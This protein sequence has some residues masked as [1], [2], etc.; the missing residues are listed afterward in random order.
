MKHNL[1]YVISL[2]FMLLLTQSTWADPTVTIIKQLNGAVVTETSPGVV[3][4]EIEDDVCTLTVTPASGYYVTKDFITVYS[5]VTGG[6]AQTPRRTNP[7]LDN[8]PIEVSDKGENTDP[9]GVTTYEFTMPAD[10]SDAEVTVDFQSIVTYDLYIGTTQVT[11]LN[12]G[13][14][15]KDGKV[16][17]TPA[18]DDSDYNTLTLNGAVL[19]NGIVWSGSDDLSITIKG[20]SNSIT[21]TSGSCIAY[22]GVGAEVPSIR[23]ERGSDDDCTLTLSCATGTDVITG[24]S[25]SDTP[26]MPESGFFWLPTTDSNKA[27]S[28][29]TITS[30]PFSG[31]DGESAETAFQIS[32]PQDLMNLSILYN[33]GSLYHM[34]YELKNDINCSS[35]TGFVPIGNNGPNSPFEGYFNGNGNKISN[36]TVTVSE[37]SYAG[38]FGIVGYYDNTESEWSV[39]NLVLENCKFEGADYSG[40]IAGILE[41]G[42][43]SNCTVTNCTIKGSQYAGGIA[44]YV[45]KESDTTNATMSG[46]KVTG[47]TTVSGEVTDGELSVGVIIGYYSTGTLSNN[48]YEYTVTTSAKVGNDDAEAKSGYTPRGIGNADDDI[49]DNNGAVMYTQ[50]LTLP[51]ETEEAAVIAVE[52]TYYGWDAT[53]TGILVAPGQT[54]SIM[55]FPGSGYTITSLTATNTKTSTVITTSS[56]VVDNGTKYTFTMPDAPVTVTVTTAEVYYLWIGDTQVTELNAAHILGENDETVTFTSV[57]DENTQITT[58]TLTLNG[59]ALTVPVIV[60]LDNLTIDIKGENTITTD[61]TCIQKMDNTN[62]S[63]TFKSTSDEVGSLILTHEGGISQIGEGSVTVSSEL[64]VLLT[65]YGYNDYTSRLYYMTDGSTSVAKI[66]PSLGVQVGETQVY[67]GNADNVFGWYDKDTPTVMFDAENHKLTLIGANTGAI[68]TSL[69]NLTIE[70]VGNNTLSSGGSS[71]FQ[72]STGDA[73]TI[74]IQSGETL[75]SLTLNMSYSSARD[76]FVGNN[77]TLNIEE[78]LSVL[79]GDLYKNEGNENTVVIGANT[80]SFAGT[81]SWAT[82]YGTKD[83]SVPTGL[84]A[85]AVSNVNTTTGVVTVG[86][87][88]GYIPANTGVLLKRTDT[89]V[90]DYALTAYTKQPED[91]DITSMLAGTAEEKTVASINANG[92]TVYVLY[93]DAFVKTTTGSIPANRGYLLLGA[94][95][96]N[97]P[98]APKLTIEIGDGATG[99]NT[100]H[101]SEVMVNDYYDLSGRKLSSVPTKSGLYIKNGKKILVK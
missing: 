52:G 4:S 80:V 97:Q 28:S 83:F 81:N 15:F 74:T 51:G 42:T 71:T 57:F 29:A 45:A 35:L 7:N 12:A 22:S 88:I 77:V 82:Y 65:V 40:A 6:V 73:V 31:G 70:L 24:F 92:G 53:E 72:S 75:G 60:G 54:A 100:V 1:K 79:S 14:V 21:T 18:G 78:P 16:S 17:F 46:C 66:V 55:V 56:Q 44:G 2:V 32:T 3:T 25:D 67:S 62:P 20:T 98:H 37:G 50:A 9:T 87:P 96:S 5:V 39:D 13:D 93:K 33:N 23:F 89:T 26:Y 99:I 61:V 36:L 48:T 76:V 41:S 84:K 63:L 30:S 90:S 11:E 95:M 8:D 64:A 101:G 43:I 69:E 34:Y 47:T 19:T 91:E 68:S 38:L 27:I 86:D 59:A 85:Y 58:N 10:G 94:T 49:L